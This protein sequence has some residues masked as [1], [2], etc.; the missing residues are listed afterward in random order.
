LS[1]PSAKRVP[2]SLGSAGDS[3]PA[4]RLEEGGEGPRASAAF[5][6][7]YRGSGKTVVG[8]LLADELGW[9]LVDTDALVE[10][11]VGMTIAE[12]FA[13]DGEA[14]FRQCESQALQ[15][16]TARLGAG[17]RLLV[18]TGGGIILD[19]NNVSQMRQRGVVVWLRASVDVLERRIGGDPATLGARPALQGSSSVSEVGAVL[20]TRLPL[21]EAAAHVT[22]STDSLTPT[23]VTGDALRLILDYTGT[24]D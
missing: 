2:N 24:G 8:K 4:R 13:Q 18:S 21:Y 11:A 15:A 12:Y 7:G 9:E 19:P 10:H 17:E 16:V 3:A 20:K 14:A 23:Q 5:L 1:S 22:I 6:V